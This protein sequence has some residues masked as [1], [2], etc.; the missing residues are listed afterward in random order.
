LEA[1]FSAEKNA[2][3]SKREVNIEK[4]SREPGKKKRVKIKE[5]GKIRNLRD[6]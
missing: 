4:R 2:W 5:Q 6:T 3:R 1:Y